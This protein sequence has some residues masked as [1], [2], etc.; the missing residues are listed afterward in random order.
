MYNRCMAKPP[1][2]SITPYEHNFKQHAE[3]TQ[4]ITECI[5]KDMM[6]ISAVTKPE[7]TALISGTE[8]THAYILA[9]LPYLSDTKMQ[10]ESCTFPAL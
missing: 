9:S 7:F 6:P 8:W 2:T 10:T 5:V 3:I 1:A 4:V